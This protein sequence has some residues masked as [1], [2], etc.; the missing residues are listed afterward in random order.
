MHHFLR[1]EIFDYL[2]FFNIKLRRCGCMSLWSLE[3]WGRQQL[4][5]LDSN[6]YILYLLAFCLPEGIFQ[7]CIDVTIYIYL[8]DQGVHESRSLVLYMSAMI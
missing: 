4:G 7:L 1:K 8:E 5:Q 6:L 2:A 3:L